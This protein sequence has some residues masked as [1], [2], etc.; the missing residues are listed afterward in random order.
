VDNGGFYALHTSRSLSEIADLAATFSFNYYELAYDFEASD[1]Y[2]SIIYPLERSQHDSAGLIYRFFLEVAD[3]VDV[4]VEEIITEHFD[5][6]EMTEEEIEDVIQRIANGED[7]VFGEGIPF[8][9]AVDE[10]DDDVITPLWHGK[11]INSTHQWLTARAFEIL[12]NESSIA[13]NLNAANKAVIMQYSDWPDLSSSGET[14]RQNSWH[15]Y[16]ADRSSPFFGMNYWRNRHHEHTAKSR[17]IFWYDSGVENYRRGNSVGAYQDLGKALHYLQDLNSPPH[18]GDTAANTREAGNLA[19]QHL[20]FE[21]L[22]D[23][24]RD[25]FRVST[26]GLYTN[27]WN[28]LSVIADTAASYSFNLYGWA[29]NFNDTIANTDAIRLSLQRSQRDSAGLI[30]RFF[31]DVAGYIVG[32]CTSGIDYS[33]SH[34]VIAYGSMDGAEINLSRDTIT[35]P[36]GY[37]PVAFSI[38][39]GTRWSKVG[40]STFNASGLNT[41]LRNGMTLHLSDKAVSRHTPPA[42]AVIITFPTINK[43][44][45]APARMFINYAIAADNT[46]AT[47]GGWVLTSQRK[48][49][50]AVKSGVEVGVRLGSNVNAAGYG[51]FC[52]NHGV[53]ITPLPATNRVVSTRYFIRIPP[54]QHGDTF[55]AGGRT[56]SI[57]AAGEQKRPNIKPNARTGLATI[58]A[59]TRVHIPGVS[60]TTYAKSTS[61]VNVPS[62]AMIRRTAT[63]TKPA[64]ALQTIP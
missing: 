58:P 42:D 45:V 17:M 23:R 39:G 64:S 10:F 46:G 1:H 59:N 20:L 54:V 12:G 50:V 57:A 33:D 55:T 56:R 28:N 48:G 2:I 30:Y 63:E 22:A 15:F 5:I 9:S 16:H 27:R 26:G 3:Y 29:Y 52:I 34:A 61:K 62:G 49:T 47:T 53:A 24:M 8:H 37:T 36:V 35:F 13:N 60:T 32:C 38:N 4:E 43:R 51:R 14:V 7:V 41:R 11:G 6:E 31:N 40:N 25:R 19:T 44:P 21:N 18:T